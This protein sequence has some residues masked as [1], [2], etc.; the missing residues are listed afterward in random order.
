[1]NK[2]S[3]AKKE[4]I[5]I[6]ES[7]SGDLLWLLILF[8]ILVVTAAIILILCC[9]CKQCP[10]YL[11]LPPKR[12]KQTPEVE[13][14]EKIKILGSGQGRESKSVQVA[15]WFGRREAWTP[16]H[17]VVDAEAESLR[18]HEVERGSDRGGAK[19]TIYRQSQIHQEPSRDHLYIR[20]GNT[21][22]LRLITRGGEQQRPVT[23]VADQTYMADNGKDILMRR[24]IDQQQ[25]EAA[26]A[27]VLLPNAVNRLQTEHELLE[28]SLRQQNAL[29]RQILLDRERDL[30]L[31]TQSLPA[32][33]QTDQDA[34]TQTEPQYLRPQDAKL[35][36]IMTKARLV[37][38]KLQLLKR[39]LKDETDK[40][41]MLGEK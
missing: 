30:R 8:F 11:Y 12:R 14:V 5:R 25:A 21:D 9:L 24:F 20:E 3:I 13:K 22:I 29:L 10:L 28:A 18:R 39:E 35:D 37:M 36:P 38:M 19:R 34:G 41:Y 7:N 26:K 16:E 2:M 4:I 17:V 1:M 15:E 33:T 32:G 27:Q 31:E 23:L 40:K 6:K